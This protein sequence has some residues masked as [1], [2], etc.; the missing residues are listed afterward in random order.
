M[1]QQRKGKVRGQ[2]L[3]S[4]TSTSSIQRQLSSAVWR[5]MRQVSLSLLLLVAACAP[6][7]SSVTPQVCAHSYKDRCMLPVYAD[8]QPG[9]S[10]GIGENGRVLR[11]CIAGCSLEAIVRATGMTITDLFPGSPAAFSPDGQAGPS[12]SYIPRQECL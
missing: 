9:L 2:L 5:C 3:Q 11:K 12:G 1:A 4:D 6:A 8:R 10:I 7:P